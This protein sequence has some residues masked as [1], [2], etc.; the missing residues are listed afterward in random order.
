MQILQEQISVH[1]GN[2]T[3]RYAL[4]WPYSGL[5]LFPA[6]APVIGAANGTPSAPLQVPT[7]Q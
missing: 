2:A 4:G 1:V 7:A 5:R 3:S 6:K